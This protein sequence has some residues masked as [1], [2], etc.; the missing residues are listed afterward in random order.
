MTAIRRFLRGGG[1]PLVGAMAVFSKVRRG[2]EDEE[3]GKT[4]GGQGSGDEEMRKT[5]GLPISEA[6]GRMQDEEKQEV[7]IRNICS[8]A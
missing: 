1:A 7:K 6:S 8:H 4:V 3:I 5:V 2:F